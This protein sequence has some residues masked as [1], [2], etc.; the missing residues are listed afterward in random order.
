MLFPF[1][2]HSWHLLFPMNV[3]SLFL[4]LGGSHAPGFL[5][6]KNSTHACAYIHPS[7]SFWNFRGHELVNCG[8]NDCWLNRWQRS[9]PCFKLM[10]LDSSFSTWWLTLSWKFCISNNT[11][12]SM[13]LLNIRWVDMLF[14]AAALTGKNSAVQLIYSADD[15]VMYSLQSL[16]IAISW[17]SSTPT[18]WHAW[19]SFHAD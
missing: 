11:C 7:L 15:L 3:C 4:C 2:I 6:R 12:D 14:I 9:P 16:F 8:V 19:S 5:R 18:E 17:T 10:A 13:F 1:L